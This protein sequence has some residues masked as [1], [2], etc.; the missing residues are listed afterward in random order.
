M[1]GDHTYHRTG[2]SLQ[3]REAYGFSQAAAAHALTN[4]PEAQAQRERM[5]LAAQRA[6]QL[7]EMERNG[8][9]ANFGPQDVALR[10]SQGWVRVPVD[11]TA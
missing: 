1:T 6:S 3:Q 9:R 7:V 8:Q 11:P 2:E 10:E 4:T 5:R